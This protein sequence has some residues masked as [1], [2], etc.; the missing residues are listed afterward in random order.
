VRAAHH[1]APTKHVSATNS[2]LRLSGTALRRAFQ[3]FVEFLRE[4]V[5][6]GPSATDALPR[7]VAAG[8]PMLKE[9]FEQSLRTAFLQFEGLPVDAAQRLQSDV[10]CLLSDEATFHDMLA[11]V[12][13]WC[14]A[15]AIAPHCAL[16]FADANMCSLNCCAAPAGTKRRHR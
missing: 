1:A 14:G 2:P 13:G 10:K 5:S 9:P 4:P 15:K 3:A 6:T 7:F 12:G 11:T 8:L 16:R